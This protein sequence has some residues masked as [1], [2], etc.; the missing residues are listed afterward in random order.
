MGIEVVNQ[1]K[2]EM[3]HAT[4]KNY[5]IE[6]DK[7]WIYDK[8]HHEVNQICSRS[9]LQEM[10]ITKFESLDETLVAALQRDIDEYAPGIKIIA[11]RVTKPRIPKSI[12]EN[13]EAIESERTKLA[14]AEQTQR[15]VEKQAE[16][17]RKRALIEAEKLKAV[18]AV[19]LERVLKQKENEQQVAE[20]TNQM[21]TAR[22]KADADAEANRARLTPEFIQYE[23][24]RSL[25]NNTKVFW[26]NKLP[27]MY[28]DGAALAP[29]GPPGSS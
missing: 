6:Y 14:V 3:V 7:A 21:T 5:T 23:A 24:V 11:I 26:G 8:I 12:K 22:A 2:R 19:Q 18:E 10:Y 4:V 20:I 25:A 1:L 17:E 9:T 28:A 29:M 15:L 27:S 16:T 13:Y